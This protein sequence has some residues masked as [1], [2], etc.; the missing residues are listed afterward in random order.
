MIAVLGK[1]GITFS[2]VVMRAPRNI[3]DLL[4]IVCIHEIVGR[5]PRE[6]F[7]CTLPITSVSISLR[8]LAEKAAGK[9]RFL[10]LRAVILALRSRMASETAEA[11]GVR[12]RTVQQWVA[13]LQCRGGRWRDRSLP[14]RLNDDQL[15]QLRRRIDTEPTLEDAARTLRGPEVRALLEREFGASFGPAA[16]YFFLQR[17][18]Y[19]SLGPLP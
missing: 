18:R 5:N 13:R 12:R 3:S 14:C 9:N 15:E 4:R 10:R 17:L 11:L 19:E 1:Q 2:D 16:V 8:A 6:S 7:P